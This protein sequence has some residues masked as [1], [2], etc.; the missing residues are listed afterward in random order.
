[1]RGECACDWRAHACVLV[2]A[3]AHMHGHWRAKGP[4]RLQCTQAQAHLAHVVVAL[5]HAQTR[6]TQRGLA[7]TA[8]LLGQ[9]HSELVQDLARVARQR[10]KQAAVTVHDNEAIPVIV[11][12]VGQCMRP[13]QDMGAAR[14]DVCR[15]S[16]ARARHAPNLR[17]C[18]SK[19]RINPVC[20]LSDVLSL[21][22]A[23]SIHSCLV[24][25][26]VLRSKSC[27]VAQEHMRQSRRSGIQPAMS[28]A[29][30]ARA[31]AVAAVVAVQRGGGVYVHSWPLH[32]FVV[33]SYLLDSFMRTHGCGHRDGFRTEGLPQEP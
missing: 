33:H 21:A 2:G 15:G 28:G 10:A 12:W 5:L 13:C 23:V 7:T 26:A 25:P 19:G 11:A 32:Q 29:R 9:V 31:A 6:E 14:T 16:L 22:Q 17:V 4:Q 3:C 8:V 24:V 20:S 30:A 27:L 1:V 18:I